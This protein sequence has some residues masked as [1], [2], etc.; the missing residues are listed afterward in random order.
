MSGL[1]IAADAT[2][3]LLGI[4]ALALLLFLLAS[5]LGRGSLWFTGY[6]MVLVAL[7][8]AFFFRDPA[9]TGERS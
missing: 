3:L 9:R 7:A 2:P 5:W 6:F 1:S 8:V 4:G